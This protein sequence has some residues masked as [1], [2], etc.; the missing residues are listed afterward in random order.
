MCGIHGIYH[1]DGQGVA[2]GELSTMGNVT[3]HRGPDDEGMHIDGACGIAMRRLSIIDLA[4]GHQ[5]LS[6]QN[7]TLWLVCNGEIYNYRELRQELVAKG[8][9]FKTGSDSEVL[10]HLY[11]AEGDNFVLRL[12]GMFGFALWDGTRRRLLIGRDRFGIKPLYVM[13]DGQRLAFSTEAKAL[14]S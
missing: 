13:Q 2:P 8:Y 14:L 4:Q 10:L 7:Q 12:N 11:D 1:F 3:R 6:N 5:P 9:H